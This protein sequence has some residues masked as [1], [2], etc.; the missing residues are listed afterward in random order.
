MNTSLDDK[1]IC[2]T[3]QVRYRAVDDEGVLVHLENGRVIVVN[4]V[5]LFIVQQLDSPKTHQELVIAIAWE[6]EVTEKQA[7]AD[8]ELY[9]AE[10]DNEQ[11]LEHAS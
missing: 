11:V 2:L 4:E 8:L 3:S 10:L 5:G 7:A 6:F 1:Q 9:L